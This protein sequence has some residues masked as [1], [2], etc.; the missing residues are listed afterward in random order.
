MRRIAAPA[1]GPRRWPA[2]LAL[3]AVLLA[4]CAAPARIDL[5]AQALAAALARQPVVLLGEVH[6]NTA[7]H[8]ARAAAL[9]QWVGAGA[10][11]ALAFEQFD[12]ERQADIDRAR[13]EAPPAGRSR[14]EHLIAQ[15]SSPRV[16]WDWALYRPYVELA[17]E[18]ELPIVAANMS[19]ADASRV[20]S[21]GFGAVFDATARS[22]LGLDALPPA[23]VQAQE[24]AIDEGHCRRLPAD[25][26]P[27]L[28]RSQTA[29]DAALALAIRPHFERGVVL[30]T[31]NGHAR[32]DIGVPIFLSA[33]ERARSL[34]IGLLEDQ[35]A[36][37]Q[38]RSRFDL[39]FVTP[40]QPR[41]D[42]CAGFNKPAAP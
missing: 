12:R 26:V 11:P 41:P 17:L 27:R 33:A 23:I 42:P 8:A 5:D 15:A 3:A 40:T 22:A 21:Q 4:A 10:R 35:A 9:R 29:R 25:M 28:A 20:A 37:P 1:F 19:R 36:T 32:K 24:Q 13:R 14:A 34:T 6:D 7:Q 18:Y 2:S 30:I 31:G 39:A 16:A 38:W